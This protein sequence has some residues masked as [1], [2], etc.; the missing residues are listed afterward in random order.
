MSVEVQPH[1]HP[2]NVEKGNF[3][4]HR[5]VHEENRFNHTFTVDVLGTDWEPKPRSALEIAQDIIHGDRQAAYGHPSRNFACIGELWRA[6][7]SQKYDVEIDIDPE[8]VAW[9]MTLLKVARA[10]TGRK[11]PDDI[12]DAAG[13]VGIVELIR[14]TS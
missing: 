4:I 1:Y 8:D 11:N 13:Y 6:Y 10:A 3:D 2:L 12:I 5:K 9:M 14:G 7:L